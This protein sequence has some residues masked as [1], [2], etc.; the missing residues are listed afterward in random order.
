MTTNDYSYQGFD[1]LLGLQITSATEDEVRAEFTVRPEL[2]QPYG[3][4]HGGGLC[5]VVETVGSVAGAVWYGERGA[6]HD[7][8]FRDLLTGQTKRP[9]A[10]ARGL[11]VGGA[12]GLSRCRRARR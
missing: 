11:R 5:S 1:Q 3:L 2:L 7:R 8:A 6:G 9:P 4:L 10:G 12:E